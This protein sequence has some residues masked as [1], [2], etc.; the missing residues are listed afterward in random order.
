MFSQAAL[1]KIFIINQA[2]K[3]DQANKAN[4]ANKAN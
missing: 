3:E 1:I 2:N 4:K